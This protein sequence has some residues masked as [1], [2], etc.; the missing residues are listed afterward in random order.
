MKTTY[1]IRRTREREA[2]AKAAANYGRHG[3]GYQGTLVEES[4]VSDGH[5]IDRCAFDDVGRAPQSHE[6]SAVAWVA[7]L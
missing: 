2:R 7:A 6:Q 4:E 3:V 5:D 1:G